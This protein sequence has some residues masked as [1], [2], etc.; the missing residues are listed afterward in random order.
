MQTLH[1]NEAQIAEIR[2]IHRLE[3]LRAAVY[4]LA[5]ENLDAHI[6]RLVVTV[7]SDGDS[8]GA[9]LLWLSPEGVPMGGGRL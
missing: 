8:I 7:D 2:Q 3:A 4:S 5:S 6:S 1:F 9:E